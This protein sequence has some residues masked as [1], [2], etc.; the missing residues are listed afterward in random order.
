MAQGR[1]G[2]RQTRQQRLWHDQ[3]RKGFSKAKEGTIYDPEKLDESLRA[4]CALERRSTDLFGER[5]LITAQI[6]E[7]RLEDAQVELMALGEELR[8]LETDLRD[9]ME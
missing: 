1:K 9:L 7:G 2:V 8:R 3:K 4:R 5:H 6:M